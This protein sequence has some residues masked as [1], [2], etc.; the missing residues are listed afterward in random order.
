MKRCIPIS[1]LPVTLDQVMA[2]LA[3]KGSESYKRIMFRHGAKEPYFGVKI[4]DMKPIQKKIRGDQT[5]ALELYATGNG[6]A[7]YLAGMVADGKKMTTAQ[8]QQWADTASWSMISGTIVP[9]VVAEHP[10]GFALALTRGG[11]G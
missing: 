10:E 9:W 1:P 5:L 3:A 7:Q 11:I 2:E 8:L 4:G 6:D